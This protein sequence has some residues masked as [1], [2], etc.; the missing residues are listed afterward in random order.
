M[1]PDHCVG[2][3]SIEPGETTTLVESIFSGWIAIFAPVQLEIRE[4]GRSIGTTEDGRIMLTAG[5]HDLE[6]VNERLAYRAPLAIDIPPGEVVAHTVELPMRQVLTS[7][8]S[9]GPRCRLTA[10]RSA[11]RRSPTSRFVIGT[12]RVLF[13]HPEH[14]EKRATITVSLDAPPDVHMDMT[15]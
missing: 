13:V 14:G 6:L 8:L 1:T 7:P 5:A 9:H 11:K 3:Y 2:P 4:N 10:S 12:R 15:R